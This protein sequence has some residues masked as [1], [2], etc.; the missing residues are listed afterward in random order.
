MT[1]GVNN[2]CLI[3]TT[4]SRRLKKLKEAYE[5]GLNVSFNLGYH[6]GKMDKR[7]R[8]IILRG[9]DLDKELE[10]IQKGMGW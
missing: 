3:I 9:V 2:M 1:L 4:K 8:G 7:N 5:K 6:Y 10:E